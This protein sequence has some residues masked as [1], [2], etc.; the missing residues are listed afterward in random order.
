MSVKQPTIIP[1][2]DWVKLAVARARD[3]GMPMVFWLD[4]ER[5]HENE[6]RTKVE[7]Y[8][9]E[10]D[11]DGLDIQ[12]MSQVGAMRHT[13]ERA[14]LGDLGVKEDDKKAT[15]LGKTLK[16]ATGKLLYNNKK[17][18]RKTGELDNRGSQF[19]LALYWAQELA[20]LIEDQELAKHFAPFATSLAENEDAVVAELAA[21][22]GSP[23]DIGGYYYLVAAKTA[24]EM[25]P[26]KTFNETLENAHSGTT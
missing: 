2:R 3:S 19:Y 7:A 22:Q 21:A 15:L 14:S 25:R 8:L 17:P 26:S 6:L 13:I 16:T 5:P 23:V 10:H 18:S 9:Q 24:A 4:Q 11:T 12:I 20:D 1:I